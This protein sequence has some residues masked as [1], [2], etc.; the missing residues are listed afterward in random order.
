MGKTQDEVNVLLAPHR[1]A[2]GD[3]DPEVRQRIWDEYARTRPRVRLED[4]SPAERRI[5]QRALAEGP[6]GTLVVQGKL[7][8]HKDDLPP[9]PDDPDLP[10][11]MVDNALKQLMVWPADRERIMKRLRREWR[12]RKGHP[13]TLTVLTDDFGRPESLVLDG[14]QIYRFPRVPIFGH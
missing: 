11:Q 5:A 13:M 8:Q 2:N 9:V 12:P 1:D 3:V 6:Q 4:L 14:R 7:V 10:F